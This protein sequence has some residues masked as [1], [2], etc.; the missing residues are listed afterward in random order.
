MEDRPLQYTLESQRWLHIGIIVLGQQR[1]LLLDELGK[2]PPQ[3]RDIR[4]TR[5][6]NLVNP[7][8]IQQRKQQVLDRHE[9]MTLIARSLERLV[10][11]KL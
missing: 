5:L 3:L 4:I 8:D 10:K 1:R 7:R 6:E 11:T 9:F 2:L